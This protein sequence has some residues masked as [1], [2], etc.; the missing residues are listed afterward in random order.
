MVARGLDIHPPFPGWAREAHPICL[1]HHRDDSA[2]NINRSVSGDTF[3]VE[4]CFKESRD[5]VVRDVVRRDF[6]EELLGGYYVNPVGTCFRASVLLWGL[7]QGWQCAT[8]T[9]RRVFAP[10]CPKADPSI[11][12]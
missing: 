12:A 4:V 3:H 9:R 10:E 8:E 2:S 7:V 6:L 1:A 11:G 5:V